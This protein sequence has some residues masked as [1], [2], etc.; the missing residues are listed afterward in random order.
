MDTGPSASMFEGTSAAS[1]QKRHLSETG[2]GLLEPYVSFFPVPMQTSSSPAI[3][4]SLI[5]AFVP[6]IFPSLLP[7]LAHAAETSPQE[8]QKLADAGDAEAQFQLGKAFWHGKGMKRDQ[9]KA[10]EYYRRAAEAKHAEALAGL[11]A[12]YALG[13]GVEEKDAKAAADYFRKSAE[14]GSSIGQ[15]NFG[16]TLIN[17]QGVEKDTEEGLG[18]VSKAAEQGL[19]KAQMYLA[20]LYTTGDAGVPFDAKQAASWA[21][22][23]ADQDY[24][25]ALNLYGTML[26]DGKGVTSDPEASVSCFQ[27]AA[28]LGHLKSYL[29]LGSAYFYGQG[30]QLDRITGMSW[31]FAG[32]ELGDGGCRETARRL[33]IGVDEDEVS[34]AR[35]L[36][37]DLARERLPSIIKK[38]SNS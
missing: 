30:I 21:K 1:S 19:V 28:D 31:W 20:Q 11:G 22:K 26:R 10:I 6:L 16:S 15:M 4:R 27:K 35:K 36:G 8:L 7:S 14:L 25:P 9:A 38:A 29:N 33:I 3:S 5:L 17:G 18:W 23:A 32:E 24:P 13:H 37:K 12:A 2:A 34:K